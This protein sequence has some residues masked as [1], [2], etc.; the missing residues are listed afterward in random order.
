MKVLITGA[1]GQLGR[2]LQ[3]QVPAAWQVEAI[4]RGCLDLADAD[5]VYAKV[6][7]GGYDLVLNAAAH[8]A[9]DKA[10]N[11]EQLAL[12]INAG[13]VGA[14]AQALAETGGRLVHVS[15][16]F[17]FDG[18]SSRAYRPQDPRNP[19]NAYGR[20]KAAGEDAAG[21]DALIV[22]TA[23]VYAAGGANFVRTMLRLMRERE[24][25]RVVVD[26]IGAPTWASG[27]AATLL[28][29]VNKQ[30]RGIFHHSDAGVTSWYDFA[31][32][33]HEEGKELGLL[34]RDVAIVPISASAYPTPAARPAFSLLDSSKTRDILGDRLQHWRANLRTMLKE[35]KA[36]G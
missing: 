12:A 30:A 27:L 35:E 25:L 16:D 9:V 14:M 26:Q 32:A 22:R 29:L 8:T 33:I 6:A 21:L 2:A 15:T 36:L 3:A 11:E 7:D 19:I 31:V 34:D 23:W 20:T 1:H 13:A 5:A 10:E 4:G 28:G 17:V 24:E 18:T